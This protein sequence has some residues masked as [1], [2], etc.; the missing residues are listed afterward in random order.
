MAGVP[1][2]WGYISRRVRIGPAEPFLFF[3]IKLWAAEEERTMARWTEDD[4][5][6]LRSLAGTKP[7]EDVAAE[8]GRTPGALVVQASKLGVSLAFKN[9][10]RATF[11]YPNAAPRV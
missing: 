2:P 11:H 5:A 8:L 1:R 6:K 9:H 7:L 10:R 3:L 4:N